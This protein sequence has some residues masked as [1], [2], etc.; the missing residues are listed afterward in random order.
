M[1]PRPRLQLDS[2]GAEQT[3]P[4]GRAT[5]PGDVIAELRAR[6]VDLFALWLQLD[7]E[8]R[9]HTRQH[10]PADLTDED[11][12]DPVVQQLVELG[13]KTR[14]EIAQ[15]RQDKIREIEGRARL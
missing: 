1:R 7:T 10:G 13:R 14:E 5:E 2:W 12:G 11:A 15:E 8:L 9:A 4:V 3:Q 6:N